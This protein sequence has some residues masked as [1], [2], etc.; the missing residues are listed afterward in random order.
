M[1]TMGTRG[2]SSVGSSTGAVLTPA[3]QGTL[4]IA[5]I[6]LGPTLWAEGH[7]DPAA[8]ARPL[9]EKY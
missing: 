1:V 5:V 8:K 6:G 2:M 3:R 4:H 7:Q 9:L